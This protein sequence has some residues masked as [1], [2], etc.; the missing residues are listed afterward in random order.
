VGAAEPLSSDGIG[1]IKKFTKGQL[2]TR[3]S[4]QIKK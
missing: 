4:E 1:D 2:I 3:W